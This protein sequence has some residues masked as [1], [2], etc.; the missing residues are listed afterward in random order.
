MINQS[1]LNQSSRSFKAF[2]HRQRDVT[3]HENTPE[4][5]IRVDFHHPE[6]QLISGKSLMQKFSRIQHNQRLRTE[7]Q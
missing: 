5:E 1:F 7:Q 6:Q 4:E 3:S 2:I